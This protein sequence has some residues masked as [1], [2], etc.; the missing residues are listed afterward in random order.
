MIMDVHIGIRIYGEERM[1]QFNQVIMLLMKLKYKK[2]FFYGF[3]TIFSAQ[4]IID[5]QYIS[6][7]N[8]IFTPLLLSA[9]ALLDFDLK[10]EDGSI[11]QK[12]MPYLYDE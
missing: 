11:V 7:Y 2:N 12:M 10:P 9:R 8:L 1:S 6:F 5:D 3:Y 4:T